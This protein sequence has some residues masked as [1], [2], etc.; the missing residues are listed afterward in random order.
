MK[1]ITTKP[2]I[3]YTQLAARLNYTALE[4]KLDHLQEVTPPKKRKCIGDVL[5]PIAAKLIELRKKGWSYEHLTQQLNDFGLPL[6]PAAL[7]DYLTSREKKRPKSRRHAG[8][9]SPE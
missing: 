6:R 3:D 7:R 5:S 1:T 2:R 9:M 8:A 4:Q